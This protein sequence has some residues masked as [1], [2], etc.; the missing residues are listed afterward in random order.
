MVEYLVSVRKDK[1]SKVGYVSTGVYGGLALGRLL[2]AEPTYR[3]GERRMLLLYSFLCLVLQ[4]VFWQV[5]E[6]VASAVAVSLMG[7]LLGP[8]FA[9]VSTRAVALALEQA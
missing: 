1:L 2:L 7:F 5:K 6:L 8:F 9:T 4:V 3:F